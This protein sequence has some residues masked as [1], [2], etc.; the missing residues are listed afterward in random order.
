MPGVKDVF[1]ITD[2]IL[3]ICNGHISPAHLAMHDFQ[4]YYLKQ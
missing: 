2:L 1:W 3:H 4:L